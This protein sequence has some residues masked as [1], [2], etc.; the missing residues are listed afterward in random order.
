[1]YV[2][3]VGQS[4][5]MYCQTGESYSKQQQAGSEEHLGFGTFPYLLKLTVRVVSQMG[6]RNSGNVMLSGCTCYLLQQQYQ[7]S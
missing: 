1:M 6:V 5:K 7:K 4:G 3:L 2:T